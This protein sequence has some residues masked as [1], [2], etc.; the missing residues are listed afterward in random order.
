M[1]TDHLRESFVNNVV[2]AYQTYQLD[3]IEID[4]EYPG[5]SGSSANKP[6][7]D[8]TA[9]FLEFLRSLRA[10]LPA[11]AKITA[12]VE[13]TP[14]VDDKGLPLKDVSDFAEVLD[15]ILIM[16]Y[17]LWGCKLSLSK[18][19]A[20]TY[21]NP[22]YSIFTSWSECSFVRCLW[23]FN[24]AGGKCSW[25]LH[26]LDS[27]QFPGLQTRSWPPFLWLYLFF[28]CKVPPDEI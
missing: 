7:A 17:D 4:W 3:G 2:A 19:G 26:C 9:N 10:A 23:Q 8:D 16:N 6:R 12:A 1:A 24:T 13:P 5:H 22:S 14:F 25:V 27:S 20:A 28:F 11:E 18:H 15:W 21:S